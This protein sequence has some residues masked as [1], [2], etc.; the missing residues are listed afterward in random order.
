MLFSYI[1]YSL[2][3][4]VL[5]LEKKNIKT[6]TNVVDIFVG[7]IYYNYNTTLSSFKIAF[8]DKSGEKNTLICVLFFLLLCLFEITYSSLCYF[9][10]FMKT[11]LSGKAEMF[12]IFLCKVNSSLLYRTKKQNCERIIF[13]GL[14]Q[15]IFNPP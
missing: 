9:N 4:K 3:N 2:N 8:S 14:G 11:V 7:I 15:I 1:Y 5:I 6:S 10:F 13:R 12:S